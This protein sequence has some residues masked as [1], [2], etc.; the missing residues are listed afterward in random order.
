MGLDNAVLLRA[1]QVAGAMMGARVVS[2]GTKPTPSP[3]KILTRSPRTTRSVLQAVCDSIA[4]Q[5]RRRFPV[6]RR[7]VR[8]WRNR[9]NV[10][11]RI[12]GLMWLISAAALLA[13]GFAVSAAMATAI[14]ERGRL[15]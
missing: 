6:R 1:A 3:A 14:L 4:Y 15:G 12:S 9:N 13:A 10:L 5:I 7:T 8:R 2:A 11:N